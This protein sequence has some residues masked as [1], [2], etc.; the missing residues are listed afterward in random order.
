[1]PEYAQIQTYAECDEDAFYNMTEQY[2]GV[3][4]QLKC[5]NTAMLD[6]LTDMQWPTSD[7]D[8]FGDIYAASFTLTPHD[9]Q[10][11]LCAGMDVA[12]YTAIPV[13]SLEEQFPWVGI[14]IL[15]DMADLHAD[16]TSVYKAGVGASL[17]QIMGE[18]AQVFHEVGVYFTNEWQENR[19]WRAIIE[20][21]REPW[22][23]DLGIFPRE[24][25]DH[26][27][28]IPVGFQGTVTPQS[29]GFAQTNRWLT[30]PWR[31]KPIPDA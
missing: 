22:S 26:F 27:S 2:R 14:N 28:H 7:D 9:A 11:I 12:I 24:L 6:W 19:S 3:L 13:H 21:T 8:D 16:S 25:A 4:E 29:F 20:D 30:L 17:W 23:F 31:E 18:L 1:M 5:T 15:F 10:P